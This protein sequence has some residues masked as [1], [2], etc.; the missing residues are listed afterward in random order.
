MSPLYLLDA[1]VLID[2]NRDYYP[3]DRVPEFWSWLEYQ[4]RIGRAAIPVEVIDELRRGDDRLSDWCKTQRVKE[5]L[6]LAEEPDVDLV[7]R[8]VADGYAA[9]L[10]DEEIL[11]I[12]RDPFLVAYGLVA[13]DERC[14]VT[15]ER[16][17]PS[18]IRANRHLPDVCRALGVPSC[19]TFAF[20]RSL[21]FRTDW[22]AHE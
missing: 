18:R 8:V 6:R 12:G 15:T 19:D 4:G 5:A 22:R 20:L 11:A 14:V 9:D 2:A 21:D 1:N 7:R 13:P 17:R 3:L 10:T 16:S